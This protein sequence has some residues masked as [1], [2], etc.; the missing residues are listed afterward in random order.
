M[1]IN[2]LMRALKRLRRRV[3]EVESPDKETLA[4][5]GARWAR[6]FYIDLTATV[7]DYLGSR[8]DL[9]VHTATTTELRRLLR[10]A[11]MQGAFSVSFLQ[12]LERGDQ[13]KFGGA[14]LNLGECEAVLDSVEVTARE[15][16]E[17]IGAPS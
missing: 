5:R 15:Y 12:V 1:P 8:L 11:E 3:A 7:R 10:S 14:S 17:T 6:G 4:A 13:V 16:E 2:R 9:P